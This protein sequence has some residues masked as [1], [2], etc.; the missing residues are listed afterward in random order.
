MCWPACVVPIVPCVSMYTELAFYGQVSNQEYIGMSSAL[1]L[2]VAQR[3]VC[4]CCWEA[5]MSGLLC[6]CFAYDDN[7]AM[8]RIRS[9]IA[10]EM[11]ILRVSC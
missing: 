9:S 2:R 1:C 5:Y 10:D 4:G 11:W 7:G 6:C 8:R 3:G